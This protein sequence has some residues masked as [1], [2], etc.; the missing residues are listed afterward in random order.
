MC[1][2]W[3]QS[4]LMKHTVL[5]DFSAINYIPTK[6]INAFW[7]KKVILGTKRHEEHFSFFLAT[8][9]L[10]GKKTCYLNFFSKRFLSLRIS[11]DG[12]GLMR[13]HTLIRTWFSTGVFIYK[14]YWHHVTKLSMSAELR[15]ICKHGAFAS[16]PRKEIYAIVTHSFVN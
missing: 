3:L 2:A 10:F 7:M 16:L 12:I 8:I 9:S 1:S 13:S 4:S 11:E 6:Y 14:V 5:F 15:W